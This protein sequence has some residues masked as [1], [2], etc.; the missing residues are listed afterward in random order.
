M[1]KLWKFHTMEYYTA[2]KMTEPEVHASTQTNP[3]RN[4]A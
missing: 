2:V 3:I 1:D 4:A